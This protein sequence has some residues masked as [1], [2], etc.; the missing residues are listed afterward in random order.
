M[1]VDLLLVLLLQTEDDLNWNDSPL[2]SSELEVWIDRELCGVLVDMSNDGL[3]IDNV[4]G[5]TA[6][7]RKRTPRRRVRK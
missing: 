2:G 5:D 7:G 6:N 3:A 1:R 4:L